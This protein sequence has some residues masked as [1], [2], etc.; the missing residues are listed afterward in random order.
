MKAVAIITLSFWYCLTAGARVGATLQECIEHYGK[1]VRTSNTNG[2][3]TYH[4]FKKN[5]VLLVAGVTSGF[6]VRM[7]Y[8]NTDGTKLSFEAVFDLVR[9]N[10][11]DL[12]WHFSAPDEFRQCVWYGV[13]SSRVRTS[14]CSNLSDDN[15]RLFTP[16][17]LVSRFESSTPRRAQTGQKPSA[18]EIR[19]PQT[20]QVCLVSGFTDGYHALMRRKVS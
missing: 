8:A 20:S 6:V 4:Y 13:P 7:I 12:L 15:S 17:S 19:A 11:A 10:G 9:D 18:G 2:D 14:K 5:G 3:I 16:S 1:E